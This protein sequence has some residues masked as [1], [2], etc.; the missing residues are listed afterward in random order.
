MLGAVDP[1]YPLF[2]LV[3]IVSSAMLL[4]VLL[5]SFVRQSWNLGVAFLCFWLLLE[6]VV[7]A[8]NAIIWSDNADIRLYVYCDIGELV[9]AVKV[10]SPYPMATLIITRQLHLIASLQSVDLDRQ[11]RRREL[12]IEWILGLFIPMLVAGPIYYINQGYRF[13][14]Y[15]GFG[16]VSA[17][18]TSGLVILIFESWTIVPPL[19][20]IIFYY[21]KVVKTCYRQRRD[22]ND[23][24]ESNSSVSRTNYLRVAILASIDI[25]LTLPN[26]IV[27]IALGIALALSAPNSLPFYRGWTS[28]HTDWKPVSYSYAELQVPG[29]GF[30]LNYFTEWTSP[31][32]AL[33]IFGLFGLTSEARASYRR[34]ICTIGGWFGWKHSPRCR[35]ASLSEIEFGPVRPR[36]STLG[37]NLEVGC[38]QQSYSQDS[39][40][41][42][43]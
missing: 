16:C 23:F 21:P 10:D 19:I 13:V 7:D 6:N 9:I 36:D 32:L 12:A 42:F 11:Q 41:S 40:H 30:V 18:P 5:T 29:A 2:P 28:L 31:V 1:T 22:I 35:H 43:E 3:L 38:V 17:T 24:M 15:E 39:S 20:S 8:A 27:T 33:T 25:F 4:L 37:Y 14:V 26:G 34:I